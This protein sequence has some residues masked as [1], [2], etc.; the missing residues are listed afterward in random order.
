MTFLVLSLPRSRT[1]WLSRF[2]TY[3]DWSCSHEQLRHLRSLEDVDAWFS[4]DCTGTAETAAAMWWR[5][6]PEGVKIVTVRRPV[7][8]VVDSLMALPGLSF[9]RAVLEQTMAAHDRKLDQIE[10][11]R[12]CLSVRYEDLA[13]EATCAAIFEH[14]LPYTHDHA[15]WAAMEGQ[16]VQCDMRALM[17][18][19]AAYRPALEKLGKV[20]KHRILARMSLR[21]PVAPDGMTLACEDFA[22]WLRDARPMI[23]EHLVIVGEAPDAWRTKNLPLMQRL[24]DAGAMQIMTARCNGRMFGYR[25]TLIAPSLTSESLISASNL[26]FYADPAAPGLGMKL[27]RA[28]LRELKARGVG[29]VFWEC[30]TRG[31]GPKLSAIPRRLGAVEHGHTYRLPLTEH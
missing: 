31:S 16:N 27:E 28:A 2:L 18:Y 6:I 19:M 26:T 25:M 14:C 15:H 4:Q 9:D 12:D 5:L 1:T 17:R 30:G 3:G 22:T 11:R 20:A 29:D 8:E 10:A 23:E 24:Y 13:D 21:E 7:A